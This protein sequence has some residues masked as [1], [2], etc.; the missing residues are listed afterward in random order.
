MKP[1]NLETAARMAKKRGELKGLY[2]LLTSYV[3]NAE[4]TVTVRL[5]YVTS[6]DKSASIQNDTFNALMSKL[7]ESEIENIDKFVESL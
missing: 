1:E 4:V 7:V 6:K 5:P 2:D 3:S